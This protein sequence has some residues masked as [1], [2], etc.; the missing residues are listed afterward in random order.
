MTVECGRVEEEEE[1]WDRETT[2]YL[3][4]SMHYAWPFTTEE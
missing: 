2:L 1:R 4:I 3:T